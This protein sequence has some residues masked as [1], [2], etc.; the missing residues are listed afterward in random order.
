MT[1]VEFLFTA[2]AGHLVV[3]VHCCWKSQPLLNLWTWVLSYALPTLSMRSIAVDSPWKLCPV[4]Q[5]SMSHSP[6]PVLHLSLIWFDNSP[7]FC[8]AFQSSQAHF[9]VLHPTSVMTL[10]CGWSVL[11]Y[12]SC[13]CF[14]TSLTILTHHHENLNS[15]NNMCTKLVMAFTK[16]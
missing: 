13:P 10:C 4:L 2:A 6:S 15:I 14:Q 8:V 1:N 16:S 7:I 5:L 11:W 3:P 9:G 12:S